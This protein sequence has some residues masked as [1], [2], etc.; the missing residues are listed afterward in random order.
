MGLPIYHLDDVVRE[1]GSGRVRALDERLEMIRTI[2]ASTSWVSEGVQAEWTDELCAKAE[3]IIW[4]DQLTGRTAVLRVARRFLRDGIA[5][6]RRRHG[7]QKYFRLRSYAR[8]LGEFVRFIGEIRAFHGDEATAKAAEGGSRAA[9]V[10]QLRPYE[11][12]VLHCRTQGDVDDLIATL[13]RWRGPDR[14]ADR[15]A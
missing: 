6:S 9:T 11:D 7:L 13:E 4:L 15:V 10:E 2:S 12:K 5:E 1:A 3:V 14:P 8:H